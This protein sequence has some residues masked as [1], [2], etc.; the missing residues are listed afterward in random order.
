MKYFF[1]LGSHPDISTAE[2]KA[3][4]P[5]LPVFKPVDNLLI[6]DSPESINP[7]EIIKRL[8]GTIKF[9]LITAEINTPRLNS[10]LDAIAKEIRPKAEMA[11]GKFPYGFSEYGL[12]R[13]NI[14]VLGM[15]TKKELKEVGT[16]A[17]WVISR[18]ATLSSVVVEQNHLL[19]KGAEILL[20][21]EKNKTL[22]GRTLAVQ[23]FK[24]LSF[25]DYGRPGRDDL[26][27]MLPP[28][29]A[30]IMINLAG[31]D[32]SA[33]LLDPF[34]GSGTILAEARLMGYQKISG[35]D[36]SDKAISDTKTNL[37]WLGE[38]LNLKTDNIEL[39]KISATEISSWLKPKS[40]DAVITEPYLGPSRNQDNL[41]KIITELNHLYAQTLKELKKI[42]KPNGT[43][44]MLW[45]VFMK[46][47][48]IAKLNPS[49]SDWRIVPAEKEN[50]ITKRPTLIYGRV[51]Q[52]VWREIVILRLIK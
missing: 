20:I 4:F 19:D 44:V 51:G 32:L 36:L 24:E 27:G 21:N 41:P 1:V 50:N 3:I 5:K 39:K 17:R 26:S 49:F 43:V 29:L 13:W 16:S 18:E 33:S 9:G 23:L 30:Q 7:R 2:I 6:L 38:K 15:E 45:P 46:S 52:K 35:S 34:C 28:K 8:G 11:E 40:V 47:R 14:K 12:K 42:I 25:R 31:Q 48:P 37:H 10:V 22:I